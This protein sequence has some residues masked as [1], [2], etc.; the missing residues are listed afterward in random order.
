MFSTLQPCLGNGTLLDWSWKSQE[1]DANF[2]PPGGF[3]RGKSEPGAVSSGTD[4]C[5]W[6]LV[7]TGSTP[8]I[9]HNHWCFPWSGSA[10]TKG[11]GGMFTF[12]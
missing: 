3:V 5:V 7:N 8:D 10:M 12:H 2:S 6:S 9:T 4:T 1:P 11:N